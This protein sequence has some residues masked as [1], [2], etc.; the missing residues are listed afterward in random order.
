MY[1]S[2]GGVLL[3]PVWMGFPLLIKN[4]WMS[5]ICSLKTWRPQHPAFIDDCCQSWIISGWKLFPDIHVH[6]YI[7][8]WLVPTIWWDGM[9]AQKVNWWKNPPLETTVHIHVTR[10]WL[11]Q[12]EYCVHI[13]RQM[14]QCRRNQPDIIFKRFGQLHFLQP[15]FTLWRWFWFDDGFFSRWWLRNVVWNWVVASPPTCNTGHKPRRTAMKITL[16]WNV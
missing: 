6:V 13:T 11:S 9:I 2:G 8:Y 7:L 12:T 4:K 1:K 14:W 10:T 15:T 5:F 3:Y 16:L